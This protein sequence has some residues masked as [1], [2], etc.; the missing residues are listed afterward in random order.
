ML[1]AA[2]EDRPGRP[3][4]DHFPITEGCAP[5]F[6]QVTIAAAGKT[7]LPVDAADSGDPTGHLS[8][9]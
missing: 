6:A 4:V 5:R 2:A 1:A 8:G 9:T 3:A 7:E